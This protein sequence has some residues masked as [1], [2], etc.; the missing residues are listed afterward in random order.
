MP[1]RTYAVPLSC[2]ATLIH[3]CHAVHLSFSNSAHVLC[4]S[5]HG[6]QKYPNCNIGML[7]ITTFMKLHVVAKISRTWAGRSCAVSGQ[8]ML[9]H[10]CHATPML[11]CAVT[12]R[13]HFQNSMV[14]AWHGCGMGCVNQTQLHCVNLMGKTQS[15]PKQHSMA[16]EQHVNSMVCVN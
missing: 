12:L 11:H 13:S 14:M 5:P 7:L 15:K 9:I 10:I 3:A 1:C 6:G 16:G 8:P 4:E 2:H